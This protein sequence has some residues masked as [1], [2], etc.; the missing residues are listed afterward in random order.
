MAA[1]DRQT[2]WRQGHTLTN[3]AAVGLGLV[4]PDEIATALVIV[5][6]H[7]CDLTQCSEVEPC[8]ET[9]VG[10]RI[11][12]ADGNFTHAK[13]PRQLHLPCEENG[14][15]VYLDLRARDKRSISKE[16]FAAHQPNGVIT[17]APRECSV[18]QRWLAARY[19]RAAF[20]D[21]FERRLQE[22]G[23]YKRIAKIIEP[24]G[25]HLV[26]IFFD[27]D[28]A[29]GIERDGAD[30]L[31][32]LGVYLLYSTEHDPTAAL[33]AAADAVQA[34]SAAF[35]DKCFVH[36]GWRNIE[37]VACEPISDTAMTYAM[38]VQLKKWS[39]DYFS[40]RGKEN[41]PMYCE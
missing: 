36:Q 2:L 22:T 4:R 26:A 11:A 40:L 25:M 18:L 14:A 20:P 39:A 31:Y 28:E 27:V 34:I 21:E 32:T 9:I 23:L 24:L 41:D 19:R 30:D 6:S 33:G 13:N 29:R 17:V 16:D 3:E 8:V 5:I 15:T 35:R 12:A 7:D 37:L 1:G 38:S 10:H